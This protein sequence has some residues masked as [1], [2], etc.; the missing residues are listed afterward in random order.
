MAFE[1]SFDFPDYKQIDR[2]T[3]DFKPVS[4][5]AFIHGFMEILIAEII[6]S[7]LEDHDDGA[8]WG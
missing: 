7:L 1:R 4:V 2:Y 5:P 8:R 6:E 3:P